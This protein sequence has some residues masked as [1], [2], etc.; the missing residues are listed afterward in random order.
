MADGFGGIDPDMW[1]VIGFSG[2][3]SVLLTGLICMV[4]R[5]WCEARGAVEIQNGVRADSEEVDEEAGESATWST[6]GG[7]ESNEGSE[8]GSGVDNPMQESVGD[9][10]FFTG[11]T[12]KGLDIIAA[13]GQRFYCGGPAPSKHTPNAD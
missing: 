3:G 9:P 11:D 8:G 13:E 4:W 6:C 12:G 7:G 5:G 10:R 1:F 2:G